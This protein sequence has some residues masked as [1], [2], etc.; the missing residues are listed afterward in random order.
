MPDMPPASAPVP[1]TSSPPSAATAT[2]R[3]EEERADRRVV[4]TALVVMVA[5]VLFGVGF[6]GL[7]GATNCR[8]LRPID[9]DIASSAVP[10]AVTSGEG[11]G[12]L[13]AAQG[14]D[15]Q[16][17]A[18]GEALL[19]GA[20]L[21]V[22]VLLDAPLR[23]G[24]HPS[25][26]LVTGD[27]AVLVAPEGNILAGVRFRRP[28]TVVGDG[29]AVYAL[30]VGNVITGQVDALRPL[31]PEVDGFVTGTCVDTSAVGSPLSF[32][33]DAREG[34]M[35]GLRTD[36]DGSDAV[37]ELRDPTRGRV[38]APVVTLPRAP[39]GL[40]GAR[41][42]GMIGPE[43]VVM[44]RRI[45]VSLVDPAVDDDGHALQAFDRRDGM[46]R[47]TLAPGD[48]RAVLPA[49]LSGTATLRLEVAHVDS[50]RV[51]V[52]VAPDVA[53]DALLPLPVHGPLGRLE[54]PDPRT[55]TLE[56]ALDD[57]RIIATAPGASAVGRDGPGRDEL[58]SALRSAG[59]DADDAVTQAAHTWVLIGRVLVR[60]G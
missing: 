16:T 7:F 45:G 43:T 8:Q 29:S 33:H 23:V 13:L 54:P 56:V 53:A 44:A 18:A 49:E 22:P 58:R 32:L 34:Q 10:A 20:A 15:R 24:L 60:F 47:W 46:L 30:V 42:S 25:G 57:G 3:S 12:A 27:G 26:V 14:V 37:L 31:R 9:L 19:G 35:V 51:L 11:I 48:V 59:L 4:I 17:L 1:P 2:T 55:V 52:T 36:E 50:R 6:G 39:A 21:A 38:W 41:T 40:Q 5:L 28:V